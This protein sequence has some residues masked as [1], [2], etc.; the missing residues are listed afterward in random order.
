[1][2]DYLFLPEDK[3]TAKE[4]IAAFDNSIDFYL[5]VLNS[6]VKE[7]AKIIEHMNVYKKA[8]DMEQYRIT[9]HGLKS[10]AA[11][12]G[13]TGLSEHAKESEQCCKALD[14]NGAVARHDALLKELKEAIALINTRISERQ[15]R[16]QSE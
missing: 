8:N 6:F 3:V 4:C 7:S 12:V 13:F 11:S 16:L 9:V 10:S 5:L 14:W 2:A 15:E 1:M